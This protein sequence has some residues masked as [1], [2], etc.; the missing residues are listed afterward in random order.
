VKVRVSRG[1]VTSIL[2]EGRNKRAD[3]KRH[4]AAFAGSRVAKITP[5]AQPPFTE[6][7]ATFHRSSLALP[8]STSPFTHR[9]I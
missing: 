1:L 2:L 7:F 5:I 8:L 4:H 6:R 3:P 9:E